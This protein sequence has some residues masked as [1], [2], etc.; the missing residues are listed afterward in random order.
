LKD[1][2]RDWL[3]GKSGKL[4][5]SQMQHDSDLWL[6]GNPAGDRNNNLLKSLY[7]FPLYDNQ[8]KQV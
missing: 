2:S 6:P 1:S 3:N 4:W 8:Y 7:N 5:Q